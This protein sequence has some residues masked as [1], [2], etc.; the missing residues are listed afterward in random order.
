[1]MGTLL[2]SGWLNLKRDYV[3]LALTFVLPIAFFSIF[4]S[5]FGNMAGGGGS[6]MSDVEIAVVDE[7]HSDASARLVKA[8]QDDG[9]LDVRLGPAA[10]P[11]LRYDR[12]TATEAVKDGVVYVAVVFPA[13]FGETF[14]NFTGGAPAVELIADPIADPVSHQMV[15]G[16]L[17]GVAMKAAPDLLMDYGLDQFDHWVGM[18]PQQQETV[19]GY[20]K[21]L[22]QDAADGATG[23]GGQ[24][25][26]FSGLIKVET[27]DVSAAAD[28][29]GGAGDVR[30][31]MVAF[32]A[33]AIGVMFLLFSMSGA[34]GAL[35]EEER[36]GTLER[37]LNTNVGMGRL[38]L[39]Y[40]LFASIVGF[41]QLT[42][43]FL[44]GWA[45]FDLDLFTVDHVIGFIVMTAVAAG[46]AA[47]FGLMLGTACRSEGQL[48]G[49]STIVIL[50]M[51]A[52][53]GSMFPRFL[54]PETMQ[55]VGLATFNGWAID[56]YRKVFHLD[57][58]VW[59]LWPQLLVL[60]GM[61]AAFLL[62]ARL[63]AR[64]WEAV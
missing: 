23:D 16:L 40:W 8:L 27:I 58:A 49:I 31:A 2:K 28:D 62:I 55:K 57:E 15:A 43:M 60:A 22:R 36:S 59:Q 30:A 34:M 32:Y 14:G 35:L 26:A 63:A 48:R 21:L 41:A 33:A 5:V 53:G 13:G 61:A 24:P 56:G 51:S 10:D 1:M 29:A 47:G 45:V 18:T 50:V 38:L 9:S 20:R 37:V 46:A 54:M 4:A 25:G 52:V 3:A 11:E 6:G 39:G 7:D 64:R 42:V 17:Q 44:W 19:E 12:A